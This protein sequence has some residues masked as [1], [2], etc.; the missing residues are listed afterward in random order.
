MPDKFAATWV[1]HSSISDFLS[2]PRSYYLKNVYKNPKTNKKINIVS[3]ALALGQVVHS[4]IEGLSVLPVEERFTEP[5]VNKFEKEWRKVSGKLGGFE[6]AEQEQRYKERG[7]EMIKRVAQNPGPLKNLAIKIPPKEKDFDLPYF[8]LS[9]EQNIILCGKIDWLEYLPETDSVHIID[10]KTSRNEEGVDSLQLP[11]YYLLVHYTQNRVVEKAS[12]WYL[13]HNDRPTQVELPELEEAHKRVLEIAE[14]IK[15]ARS[16]ER[17]KCPQGEAG[18]RY[19]LPF[20]QV[21]R[22]EAEAVGEDEIGREVYII[23]REKPLVDYPR[24]PLATEPMPF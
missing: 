11:I 10:F 23:P 17:Y 5:L 13:N 15:L 20:E 9:D 6:N 2:C 22:G 16:L 4:V 14:Q 8:W 12:Y 7:L 1:S 3:P 21:L 24:D 18:C 19:C